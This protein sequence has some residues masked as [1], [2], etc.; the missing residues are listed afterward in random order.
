MMTFLTMLVLETLMKIQKMFLFVL[1]SGFLRHV[2][3]GR[4]GQAPTVPAIVL[5]FYLP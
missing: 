2:T 1:F 3:E 5:K 4:L